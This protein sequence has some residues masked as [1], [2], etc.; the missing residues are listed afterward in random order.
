VTRRM[1]S[2][3]A[4]D[5]KKHIADVH[6]LTVAQNEGMESSLAVATTK[7]AVGYRAHGKHENWQPCR[8]TR[9][10]QP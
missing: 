7:K 9:L 6:C 10:I 5:L 4:K 3:V 1:E 8:M 2:N